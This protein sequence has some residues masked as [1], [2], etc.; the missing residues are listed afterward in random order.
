MLLFVTVLLCYRYAQ[1]L[2]SALWAARRSLILRRFSEKVPVKDF[3]LI[4]PYNLQRD[5]KF[6]FCNLGKSHNG[7]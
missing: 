5:R 7:G 4:F 6:S 1:G 2:K 3:I